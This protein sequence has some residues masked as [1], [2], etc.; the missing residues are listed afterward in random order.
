MKK[1]Y[2]SQIIICL[3]FTN[4]SHGQEVDQ[5]LEKATSSYASGDL[6]ETRYALQETLHQ[7]DMAI[8]AE[9][10]KILPES[11]GKYSYQEIED[12]TTSAGY[13]G[14]FVNRSYIGDTET[15]SAAI[16]VMGDSPLLSGITALLSLP[17]ITGDSNQKRIRIGSY[18]AL[19]EKN[20]DDMGYVS[21]NVQVPMGNT[22]LT[23][24]CR[25]NETESEVTEML[26]LLQLE[27]IAQLTK[28]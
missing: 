21:W 1:I 10:L 27:Q 28:K 19:M 20:E 17:M 26:S 18:R 5:Y 2:L 15:H 8:G 16:Q 7:I 3:F 12:N 6:H 22:L 4:V 11:M 13:A 24:E 23:F 9:I 25:G 14:L